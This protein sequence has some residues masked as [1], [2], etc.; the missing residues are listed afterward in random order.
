CAA[1]LFSVTVVFDLG[2]G[3][4]NL[5]SMG[6]STDMF[7]SKL[8]SNRGDFVWAR[9]LGGSFIDNGTGIAVDGQGNVYTTGNFS[10]TVDFDP[11]PGTFNLTG[12]VPSNDI[13]VSKLDPSGNFL[14]SG[15]TG[16]FCNDVDLGIAADGSGNVYTT[17]FF[18]DTADFDPG[19]GT[20][21]LTS[22]SAGIDDVFVSK[23]DPSGNFVWARSLGG[24]G[25]DDGTGLAVDG[26]GN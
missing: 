17:G 19:P 1:G 13:F 25:I 10:D 11:G 5:T 9:S 24:S 15:S 12:V 4:S 21:N 2:P 23:L 20:F 26:Q 7:I 16:G 3:T 14:W 22:A 8:D 6:G 18:S